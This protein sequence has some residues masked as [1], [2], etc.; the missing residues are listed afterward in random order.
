[1]VMPDVSPAV[2]L[3]VFD[4]AHQLPRTVLHPSIYIYLVACQIDQP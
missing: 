3:C 4:G 1:M 2:V